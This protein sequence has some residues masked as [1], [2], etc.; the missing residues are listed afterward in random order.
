MVDI[1]WIYG[2]YMV[3]IWW[4]YGGYMVDIW[5]IYMHIW[6]IYSGYMAGILLAIDLVKYKIW[7]N[8]GIVMVVL[9][10]WVQYT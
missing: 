1:W 7:V 9:E 4:I 10:F 2:G 6:W 3:D 8:G 5:W